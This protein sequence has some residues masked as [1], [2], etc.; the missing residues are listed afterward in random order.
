M[1][2]LQL[3]LLIIGLL[4]IGVVYG[5][6]W[7]QQREYGRKMGSKSA[8]PKKDRK[9]MGNPFKPFSEKLANSKLASQ[10]ESLLDHP[11]VKQSNEP[12]SIVPP[13]ME[14]PELDPIEPVLVADTCALFNETGDFVVELHPKSPCTAAALAALWPHKFDFGKPIQVCGLT[15]DAPHWERVIADSPVLYSQVRIALQLVDRSGVMSTLKLASFTDLIQS[16]AQKLPAECNMPD[17]NSSY[18]HAQALDKFC[19]EV[20]KMVGINLIPMD[21]SVLFGTQIAQTAG[22]LNLSLEADGAFHLLN[23]QG[24]SLFSLINQQNELFQH[25]NLHNLKT[26]GVTLLLD[27]PRASDPLGQFDLMLNVALQL[28]DELN[29]NLVDDYFVTLDEAAL[30]TIRT[31]IAEVEAR[32]FENGITPGSTHARRLFA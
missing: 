19:L 29:L 23:I 31:Q 3:A 4:I 1:S 30:T 9:P 15:Q 17:L 27:V 10:L 14:A 22:M 28:A 2:E 24:H 16:I 26:T 32:M 12:A 7:W 5:Y 6:G 8:S 18:Q 25:H 13:V 20:D 21:D 11:L